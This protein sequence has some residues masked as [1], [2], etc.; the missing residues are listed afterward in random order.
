[1][2]HLYRILYGMAVCVYIL[3]ASSCTKE[4]RVVSP[5][6]GISRFTVSPLEVDMEFAD[7]VVFTVAVKPVATKY[8]WE[9]SDPSIA[10]VD[11][12]DRIVPVGIGSVTF[13]CT[14]GDYARTVNAV[15]RP[16]VV[17]SRD[18]LYLTEGESSAMDFVQVLP[19]GT[20][21]TVAS[22]DADIV[23]VPDES[24]L[25]IRAVSAGVTDITVTVSDAIKGQFTVAV[26][27]ETNVI[28]AS[29]ADE[30]FYDATT[31]GHPVY[32]ITALA[33]APSGVTYA[34]GGTWSGTGKGLFLKLYNPSRGNDFSAVPA[35][36]YTAG[37][38]EFN[39]FADNSYIIDAAT[40]AKT[41]IVAGELEISDNSITGFVTAGSDIYKVNCSGARN[42]KKHSYAYDKL[43]YSYTDA[44]FTSA[45]S[46]L[47]DHNG[48]VF[49]GGVG[50]VWRWRFGL[51]AG[52]YLQLVFC[53]VDTDVPTGKYLVSGSYF[54]PGTCV[55]MGWG[56]SSLLY[57]NR[58][59]TYYITGGE[60]TVDNYTH[61]NPAVAG[62]HGSFGGSCSDSISEIGESRTI[63]LSINV[64][65]TGLSFTLQEY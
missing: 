8:V 19:E 29:V 14:A 40:G 48:T 1:M 11:E 21:Y 57:I 41:T 5:E 12:N 36:K 39:L 59:T 53:T 49:Y 65:V 60:V 16:S 56:V 34:D 15:I 33:V 51:P 28:S 6:N 46:L 55:G 30:Y 31:L 47:I 63:P 17:V 42:G 13:T 24:S 4:I 62:F 38:G 3:A 22:A 35:G 9:S 20:A 58:S 10:Y 18:Y 37:E 52:A 54:T 32:G 50:N 2:K 25:G 23:S 27:D 44:D 64:D 45:S 43:S 7:D 61:A 26:A